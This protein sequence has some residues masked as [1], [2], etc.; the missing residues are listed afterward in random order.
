MM[1]DEK[2][3]EEREKI[4]GERVRKENGSVIGQWSLEKDEEKQEAR[5][6]GREEERI[7]QKRRGEEE[8]RR[9]EEKTSCNLC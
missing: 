4:E 7:K 8:K 9:G 6:R 3:K 2:K 5:K 1:F